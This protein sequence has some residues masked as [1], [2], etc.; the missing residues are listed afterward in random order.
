MKHIY[1]LLACLFLLGSCKKTNKNKHIK[2]DGIYNLDLFLANYY[3]SNN[4][5]P[6]N[7]KELKKY[8][9]DELSEEYLVNLTK[10]PILENENVKYIPVYD[11]EDSD[12]I[13]SYYLISGKSSKGKIYTNKESVFIKSYIP[14]CKYKKHTKENVILWYR[15]NMINL[16]ELVPISI[17]KSNLDYM[18][19]ETGFSVNIKIDSLV[20]IK[21][22]LNF[23]TKQE[24]VLVKGTFYND[25]VKEKVLKRKSSITIKGV[26][27]R[28]K[29]GYIFVKNCIV[30][31]EERSSPYSYYDE[32]GDLVELNYIG[33]FNN[34]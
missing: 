11:R 20:E 1:I 15:N 6:D 19:N 12:R 13:L 34:N 26:V 7:L 27:E 31:V 29:K 33:C 4:K 16:R 28:H 22:G 18:R 5:Y 23:T 32:I 2:W 14:F 17:K 10:D 3:L 30:E 21:N 8:Y 25:K 9:S 24:G